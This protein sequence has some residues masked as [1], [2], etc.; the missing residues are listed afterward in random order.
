MVTDSP[1]IDYGSDKRKK[2]SMMASR[3]E[4]NELNALSDT[5]H[6]RRNGRSF[7]GKEMSL[8]EFMK[9]SASDIGAAENNNIKTQ[10]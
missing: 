4:V 8:G 5:W 9:G 10:Q 1:V 3:S 2:G 7:V 6:R